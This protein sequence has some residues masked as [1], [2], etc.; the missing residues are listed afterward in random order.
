MVLGS[1]EKARGKNSLAEWVEEVQISWDGSVLNLKRSE[2]H[3][4]RR[5]MMPE[6]K[7][8]EKPVLGTEK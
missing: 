8:G 4:G 2:Q 7:W 6:G 3:G 1:Q 5:E